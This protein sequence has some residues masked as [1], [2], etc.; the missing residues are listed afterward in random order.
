MLIFRNSRKTPDLGL[1]L[2]W[3]IALNRKVKSLAFQ[4]LKQPVLCWGDGHGASWEVTAGK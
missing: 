2:L 1:L 4:Q 3:Q